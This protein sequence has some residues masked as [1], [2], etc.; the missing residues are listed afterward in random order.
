MIVRLSLSKREI[1]WIIIIGFQTIIKKIPRLDI[2]R[3]RPIPVKGLLISS[4]HSILTRHDS[5][6]ENPA[7][8]G[9]LVHPNTHGTP[10]K[11]VQLLKVVS[12]TENSVSST[13]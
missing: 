3:R 6:T 13:K 7:C 11:D 8:V 12:V 10:F 5:Y 2:P 4:I 9:P 1:A